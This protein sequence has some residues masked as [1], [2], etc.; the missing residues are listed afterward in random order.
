MFNM[1]QLD[2]STAEGLGR[3]SKLYY[4]VHLESIFTCYLD[5]CHFNLRHKGKYVVRNMAQRFL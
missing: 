5:Q 3:S 1:Q 2:M 4:L